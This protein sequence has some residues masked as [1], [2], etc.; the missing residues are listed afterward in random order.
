M[1]NSKNKAFK[2]GDLVFNNYKG[3]TRFIWKVLKVE[4][5]GQDGNYS[6]LLTIQQVID[7]YDPDNRKVWAKSV[8]DSTYVSKCDPEQVFKDLSYALKVLKERLKSS[9]P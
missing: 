5:R 4:K 8:L 6:P 2:V 3:N 1:K 9:V 7:I